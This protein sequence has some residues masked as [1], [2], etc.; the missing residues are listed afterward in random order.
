MTTKTQEL[1]NQEI[2]EALKPNQKPREI[3]AS[4]NKLNTICPEGHVIKLVDDDRP[5]PYV[6]ITI[7]YDK[8]DKVEKTLNYYGEFCARYRNSDYTIT[9]GERDTVLAKS[10]A[11][12]LHQLFL[13]KNK[14]KLT[15]DKDTFVALLQLLDYDKSIIQQAA[16]DLQTRER[17]QNLN[18]AQKLQ[19]LSTKF[20]KF[21]HGMHIA[22]KQK[23]FVLFA[24]MA[25]RLGPVWTPAKKTSG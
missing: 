8:G 25:S 12:Q 1:C 10:I 17:Y 24:V 14:H 15:T 7:E 23:Q 21:Y 16:E 4:C 18:L 20:G 2:I 3:P 22:D 9:F 19:T 13:P 11:Y 6:D 5:I